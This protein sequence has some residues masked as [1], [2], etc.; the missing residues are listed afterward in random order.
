M[1]YNIHLQGY[2]GSFYPDVVLT[3]PNGMWVFDAKFRLDRKGECDFAKADDVHK[4]H[5]YRDALVGCRGAYVVHPGDEMIVYPV[6]PKEVDACI[7]ARD[8]VGVIPARTS[9]DLSI[10]HKAILALL[11]WDEE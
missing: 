8:G 5:A 2:S 1:G 3:T 4:M 9:T 11:S 7:V 10:L 6:D